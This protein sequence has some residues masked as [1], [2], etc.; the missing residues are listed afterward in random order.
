MKKL[1]Y[2]LMLAFVT[3]ASF[4]A[5]SEEEVKPKSELENGGGVGSDPI[6]G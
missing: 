3:S 1:F 2:I 6:K 5:C 4:T